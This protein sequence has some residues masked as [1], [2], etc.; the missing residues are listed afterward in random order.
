MP[1]AIATLINILPI[2][3]FMALL[4]WL[5]NRLRGGRG[6]VQGRGPSGRID[7]HLRESSAHWQAYQQAQQEKKDFLLRDRQSPLARHKSWGRYDLEG[8]RNCACHLCR[9]VLDQA[10]AEFL[11]QGSMGSG[12]GEKQKK[13]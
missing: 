4:V 5:A 13:K 8:N 10:N 6:A 3:A 11:Q 2:L 12:A 1:H 9:E 7:P